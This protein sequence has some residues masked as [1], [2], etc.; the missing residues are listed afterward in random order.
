M[1]R[2][3]FILAL[4]IGASAR[5]S[6]AAADVKPRQFN[7]VVILADDLGAAELGCYGNASH[8]T[9][10][11]DR[12]AREGMLF[13]TCYSTP[14]CS[15][16]RVMIM[17]GRYGFRTGWYNFTKR[18]G[19]PTYKD[20]T[21]DLGTAEVTFADLLKDAGYATGLSGKWQLTGAVPTLVHDCGFDDYMIWAY[22][23]NLPPGVVH[24][25]GWEN[26]ERQTTERYWHPSIV[27]NGT[28]RPTKES[29][30]GPDL[31]TDHTIDFIRRN[32]SRP[33]VAYCPM[34]LTHRPWRPTPD[35]EH[36]GQKTKP[37][38][39]ANVEYMDHLVGRIVQAVDDEGLGD[40][41]IVLFTGDNGTQGYGKG[42]VT[43]FGVRVPLIVRCPGTVRAGG[44]S[45]E[46]ADLTDVLPTLVDFAVV[47]LS[48][49]LKI[50]GVSLRP[51]LCGEEGPH[52]KWVFSYLHE[53]RILRDKRWLLEGDGR[54]YDCGDCRDGSKYV[55]VTSSTAAE[56]VL[57]RRLFEE[58][59]KDLPA[60]TGLDP[61]PTM[62]RRER[63][64]ALRRKEL[65]EPKE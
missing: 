53:Q 11:L 46:L 36:P 62:K 5:A 21:Y 48:K 20:S 43:E 35:L 50:D 61:D 15:P 18:P 12:L 57:A 56:V 19:S 27:V 29:D 16:S 55:D 39:K 13:R 41:T 63:A 65:E 10:H 34:C 32:K 23:H 60:P 44:V 58:R 54:F 14:I 26:V 24:T 40:R 51:T 4:A 47:Q 25:G 42:T 45:D 59:L 7:F 9:P 3:L 8:R 2:T 28:Y 6:Q 17:T 64:D 52:R 37:G 49:D 22:K 33:F 38:L 31:F 30:Y 1:L